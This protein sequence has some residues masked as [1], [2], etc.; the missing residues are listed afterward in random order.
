VEYDFLRWLGHA[1]FVLDADGKRIFIDPFRI[2]D[3]KEHADIVF[4]THSHMDHLSIDD[5]KKVADQETT[6]V[7]PEE[8]IPK[9]D[10]KNVIKVKPGEKKKVLGIEFETIAAYNTDKQKLQYHPHENKW[11][12]YIISVEGKRIYHAG[13]TDL[14]EEMKKV[15]TDLALIPVGGTYTMDIEEGLAATRDIRAKNFAPMHYKA[16]LGKEGSLKLEKRFGES[17]KNSIIM[18]EVSEPFY[19]F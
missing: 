6:F 15:S 17:V 9:L 5:I 14:T 13:D 8:A 12:G 16:L 19:S 3:V 7:A 11:V 1:A 10:Y 4:I 18:E 2:G